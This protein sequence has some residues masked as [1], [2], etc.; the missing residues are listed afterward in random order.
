MAKNYRR[1][2]RSAEKQRLKITDKDRRRIAAIFAAVA[3]AYGRQISSRGKG[4]TTDFVIRCADGLK[5]GSKDVYKD[6]RRVIRNGI[7]DVSTAVAGTQ[8]TYWGSINP[9]ITTRIA[10]HMERVPKAVVNEVLSGKL[11]PDGRAL[12]ARIWKAQHIYNHDIDYIIERGIYSNKSALELARD[13]EI[14]VRPDAAKPFDWSIC[15]PNV[16]GV[17]VDYNAQR[18][19]RTSVTHAY[20]R[21]LIH[22]TKDN[23][24]ITAYQWHSSNSG[25]VCP[26]CAARDGK[27]YD[28]DDVPLDHPNGMCIITPVI[29]RSYDDI[30]DEIAAWANG[31]VNYDLDKW[32]GDD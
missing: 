28:K 25:R 16:R 23:P 5:A 14:Y 11:Y 24:F 26:I 9:A 20:Q 31:G 10:K 12:S 22:S 18:L 32:L 17:S 13:L 7:V 19:A 3:I 30:A 8:A 21:A 6:V 27:I 4:L 29:K 2:M 1:A 15:Y